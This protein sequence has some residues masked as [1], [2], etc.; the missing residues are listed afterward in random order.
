MQMRQPLERLKEK[1]A[2][3]PLHGMPT[4]GVFLHR[5]EQ[6]DQDHTF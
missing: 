1:H 4:I 2:A 5:Q 3:N 6:G